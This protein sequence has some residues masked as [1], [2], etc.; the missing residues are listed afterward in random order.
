MQLLLFHLPFPRKPTSLLTPVLQGDDA[1][2]QQIRR[3]ECFF[4]GIPGRANLHQ[5]R[6][7]NQILVEPLRTQGNGAGDA[8]R[9]LLQLHLKLQRQREIILPAP[10]LQAA[11]SRP[12]HGHQTGTALTVHGDGGG[13]LLAAVVFG[14]IPVEVECQQNAAIVF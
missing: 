13:Q 5:Q 1:R 7:G 2:C 11:S 8:R 6:E 10:V 14:S 9:C 12:Q 3:A 4:Q